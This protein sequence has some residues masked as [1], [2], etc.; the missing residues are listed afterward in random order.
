MMNMVISHYENILNNNNIFD[1]IIT[2]EEITNNQTIIVDYVVSVDDAYSTECQIQLTL[3]ACYHSCKTCSDNKIKSNKTKHNC[4][5]CKENYYPSPEDNS[6]CFS[7]KE[8]KLNWYFDQDDKVFMP[9]KEECKTCEGPNTCTS[10]Q[11]G[12][13]LDNGICKNNCSPGYFPNS[14][15]IC[16]TCFQNCKT[17]FDKGSPNDMKCETCKAEQIKYNNSC[18]DID[19]SSIKSFNEPE[20]EDIK[21]SCYEKFLLYIKENSYECIPLPS[22]EEG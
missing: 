2:N 6:N 21:N 9:C 7:F 18:F 11:N 17:C 5:Q 13:V 14:N 22:E 10:C 19:D 1:F 3:N 16:A 12:F 20:N 15:S 8:K 4:I